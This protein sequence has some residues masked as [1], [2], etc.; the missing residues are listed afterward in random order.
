MRNPR[1]LALILAV[2]LTVSAA[3]AQHLASA[4]V[5]TQYNAGT[6]NSPIV[7]RCMDYAVNRSGDGVVVWTERIGLDSTLTFWIYQ[8]FAQRTRRG[9]DLGPRVLVAQY[10][11]A[12]AALTSQFGLGVDAETRA[13]CAI[14]DH[15]NI[16]IVWDEILLPPLGSGF[17]GIRAIAMDFATGAL[18]NIATVE[19]GNVHALHPDV[20]VGPE[21]AQVAAGNFNGAAHLVVAWTGIWDFLPPG[22]PGITQERGTIKYRVLNI[23]TAPA[24]QL[25]VPI[26]CTSTQLPSNT[27]SSLM[28]SAIGGGQLGAVQFPELVIDATGRATLTY[29]FAASN[30]WNDPGFATPARSG[31]NPATSWQVQMRQFDV[32]VACLTVHPIALGG[33]PLNELTI[34]TA[35]LVDLANRPVL[36]AAADHRAAVAWTLFGSGPGG[37]TQ[38]RAFQDVVVPGNPQSPLLAPV[39]TGS[40]GL[41]GSVLAVGCPRSIALSNQGRIK[42]LTA[43]AAIDFQATRLR[44]IEFATGSA[45]PVPFGPP[46]N[47]NSLVLAGFS[48]QGGVQLLPVCA[49]SDTGEVDVMSSL[50]Y[51]ALVR[52]TYDFNSMRYVPY[53]PPQTGPGFSVEL[54]GR[55]G[56][57]YMLLVGLADYGQSFLIG[58]GRHAGYDPFTDPLTT[59]LLL[60]N[61]NFVAVGTLDALGRA[62]QFFQGLPSGFSAQVY[63]GVAS[64]NANPLPA[65]L[66]SYP[67]PKSV[68]VT[69]P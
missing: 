68:L 13:R 44:D 1:P 29:V 40:Y 50:S 20:A 18:S 56:D 38:I 39:T 35:A 9:V 12:A 55:P 21:A 66:T 30:A 15:G 34:S 67:V 24:L 36:S 19:N 60:P 8:V 65:G 57:S 2:T 32:N 4:P 45:S 16:G 54:P 22:S 47:D 10:Q 69:Y 25:T 48:F 28:P 61:P 53:A 6:Q 64:L 52:S 49:A 14:D 43:D 11:D 41:F 26:Q 46:P 17:R 59:A 23:Q 58:D 33:N 7:I 5:H 3:E 42:L 31:F 51:L 63:F 62:T 37:Q 27:L